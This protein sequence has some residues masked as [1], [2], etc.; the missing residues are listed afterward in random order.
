MT[1]MTSKKVEQREVLTRLRRAA[2]IIV[3]VS[4]FGII[5]VHLS[6]L[7]TLC[8]GSDAASCCAQA[9]GMQAI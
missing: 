2:D 1:Q 9:V 8:L 5:P 3:Q 6:V 4:V 7:L